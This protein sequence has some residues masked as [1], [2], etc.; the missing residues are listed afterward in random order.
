MTRPFN[1]K[2]QLTFYG[3]YHSNKVNVTIHIV[4]VPLIMWSTLVWL[5]ALP[6]PEALSAFNFKPLVFN[7]YMSFEPTWACVFFIVYQTYYLILEPRAAL[8]YLPEF[9]FSLATANSFSH[10][11]NGMKYATAVH[12]FSWVMQFIGHGVFEKRAPALLDNI[13]GALILAPFFVHLEMLFAVGY[14]KDMH[15]E[16]NNA[17]GVKI[18]QFRKKEGDKKRAEGKAL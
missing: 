15:K 18:A 5:S 10:G 12:V 17:V 4:C 6:L 1:V 11:P 2:E 7:D 8:I 14:R 3:A 9:L 13:A 16:L